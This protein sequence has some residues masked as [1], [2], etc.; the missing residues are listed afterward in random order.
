MDPE[1]GIPEG[2]ALPENITHSHS[3]RNLGEFRDI[4]LNIPTSEGPAR[5]VL[6]LDVHKN[7][8]TLSEPVKLQPDSS[9]RNPLI[10]VVFSRQDPNT[11]SHSPLSRQYKSI[12]AIAF[13][14][15][16]LS[17]CVGHLIREPLFTTKVNIQKSFGSTTLQLAYLDIA[18]LASYSVGQFI[19]PIVFPRSHIVMFVC[20]FHLLLGICHFLLF[21]L[22]NLSGFVV[23]YGITG[24]SCAILWL[25][26]YNDLHSWLPINYRMLLITFWCCAAELGLC[27]GIIMCA[28]VQTTT[29]WKVLFMITAA[30][31]F[32]TFILL[33]TCYIK[34]KPNSGDSEQL[35]VYVP[36][37]KLFDPVNISKE[38]Y[39]NIVNGIKRIYHHAPVE[40]DVLPT[41]ESSELVTS[42][43]RIIKLCKCLGKKVGQFFKKTGKRISYIVRV[44]LDV[45]KRVKYLTLYT[46]GYTSLKSARNCFAFWI[47]FYLTTNLKYSIQYGIYATLVFQLGSCAGS[48]IAGML[49]KLVLQN[50][51]LT[52]CSISAVSSLLMLSLMYFM[53][54]G[55]IWKCFTYVF[56]VGLTTNCTEMLITTRGLKALC[57]Q[58]L[59][60]EEKDYSVSLGTTLS[61]ANFLSVFQGYI[62]I[63]IAHHFGWDK[64]FLYL[65]LMMLLSTGA[66]GVPSRKEMERLKHPIL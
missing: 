4:D 41:I 22:N 59:N 31:N 49:S 48:L 63:Y 58:S 12:I 64:M 24:F 9:Q 33:F 45:M 50:Y 44:H 25:A 28:H 39:R 18:Y 10:N 60:E 37:E 21:L 11:S 61:I 56:L 29:R 62:S 53:D 42:R 3:K 55:T 5:P 54:L 15:T 26:L 27:V 34:P 51:H 57:D 23:M 35:E 2:Y 65:T 36:R 19:T 8:G 6:E 38:N 16:F 30:F 7:Y 20:F 47:S 32:L 1:Y 52:S 13:V 46:V 17:N 40:V 14:L 66:L 43:S